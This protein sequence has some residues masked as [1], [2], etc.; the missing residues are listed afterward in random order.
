[1]ER[2]LEAL[3]D[4]ELARLDERLDARDVSQHVV[5]ATDADRRPGRVALEADGSEVDGDAELRLARRLVEIHPNALDDGQHLPWIAM[6]ERERVALV[7]HEDAV[8]ASF[9]DRLA[10]RVAYPGLARRVL[11]ERAEVQDIGAHGAHRLVVV[12]LDPGA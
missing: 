12:A 2:L 7:G 3:G 1:L 8:A 10:E 4:P 5:P 9:V 11:H 6:E